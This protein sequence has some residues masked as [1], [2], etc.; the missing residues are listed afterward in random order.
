MAKE[1]KRD[2]VTT[3]VISM[4][5][6]DYLCTMKKVKVRNR[7]DKTVISEKVFCKRVKK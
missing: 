4:G 6:K 3:K 7:Y 2:I 5:G 1:K